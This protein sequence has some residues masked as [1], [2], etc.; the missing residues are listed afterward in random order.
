VP[1]CLTSHH[2]I[3]QHTTRGLAPLARD[4]HNPPAPVVSQSLPFLIYP[5]LTSSL[6]HASQ[7]NAFPQRVFPDPMYATARQST[8]HIST[9]PN[10]A[11]IL[12]VSIFSLFPRN[13]PVRSGQRG[14]SPGSFASGPSSLSASLW[15]LDCSVNLVR[16]SYRAHHRTT[17]AF[18]NSSIPSCSP[19]IHI[20]LFQ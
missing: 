3:N 8:P 5:R 7:T 16:Q 11:P 1:L 19:C 18:L 9:G 14:T 12:S 17:S 4:L 13:P 10:G 2:P 6:T 20:D 15:S